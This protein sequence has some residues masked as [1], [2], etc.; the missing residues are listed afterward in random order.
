[1]EKLFSLSRSLLLFDVWQK[2]DGFWS[3]GTWECFCIKR[4]KKKI[5]YRLIWIISQFVWI[6]KWINPNRT[7][8]MEWKNSPFHIF[9]TELSW[10]G[11]GVREIHFDVSKEC[12]HIYEKILFILTYFIMGTSYPCTHTHTDA[13]LSFFP[14]IIS[15]HSSSLS[16]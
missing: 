9:L 8:E 5:Y 14:M 13:C 12:I 11:V 1:M 4:N 15:I 10:V 16:Y 7:M 6:G 2:L 3:G